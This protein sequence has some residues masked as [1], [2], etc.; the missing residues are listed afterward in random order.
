MAFQ[1]LE[2]ELKKP[3]SGVDAYMNVIDR[4]L[5]LSFID[6]LTASEFTS[7][8]AEGQVEKTAALMVDAFLGRVLP[9]STEGKKSD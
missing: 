5:S 6:D 7:P 1:V 8:F 9:D 2:A 3:G 4:D